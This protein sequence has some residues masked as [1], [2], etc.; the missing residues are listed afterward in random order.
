MKM[1][2]VSARWASRAGSWSPDHGPGQET[3]A[4]RGE[5]GAER[6]THE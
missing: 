5:T 2:T 1:I 3:G 6:V 4:E